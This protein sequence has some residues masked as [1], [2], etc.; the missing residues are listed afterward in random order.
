MEKTNNNIPT[1]EELAIYIKEAT[2]SVT[3]TYEQSPVVLMVDNSIIGTLGNFSASIG[4]AKSKKTFNVSAIAA[5]AL[6]NGTV[7]HYRSSFP[8]NKRTILY[9][10]TEQGEPHCQKVLQRI[11]CLAG[12]PKD[13]DS[14]NLI[15]L[16]LRK[17]SPE[18]RLA[19]VEQAIGT[20]PNL[21]L[22]IID[23]IRDFMYDINSPNEATNIISKFMQWTDD[24]Q[25]HIHTVLHQNKNDE[26][27]RGH[28]GTELNNKAETI[29][30]IEVDKRTRL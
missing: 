19:I 17:Y 10:D 5:S 11:L 12:L 13:A 18:M 24:R 8:E 27:A 23:G 4:K 30:Q 6:A 9:I 7:L 21:G 1:A 20:I 16:G 14:D 26:H 25:I 22:V 2:V 3:N 29:M 28:I 15:M